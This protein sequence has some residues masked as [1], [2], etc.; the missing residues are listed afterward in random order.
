MDVSGAKGARGVQ[1]GRDAIPEEKREDDRDQSERPA[2]GEYLEARD[3]GRLLLFLG[4]VL[5]RE[6][7]ALAPGPSEEA[8]VSEED[9]DAPAPQASADRRAR[10]SLEREVPSREIHVNVALEGVDPL[11]TRHVAARH[12]VAFR[13]HHEHEEGGQEY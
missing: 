3:E 7:H 9:I 5:V 4:Q 2:R 12:V 13:G 8:V 6:D 10:H 11:D 1:K